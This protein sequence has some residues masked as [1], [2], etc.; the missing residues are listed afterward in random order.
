VVEVARW[1]KRRSSAQSSPQGQPVGDPPSPEAT[2]GQET[3]QLRLVAVS[4]M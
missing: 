3:G 1:V 2:D 4:S